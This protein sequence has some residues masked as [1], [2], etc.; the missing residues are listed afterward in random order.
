MISVVEDP[1]LRFAPRQREWEHLETVAS[2]PG[3]SS[4]EQS[5]SDQAQA[6]EKILCHN[7]R[8]A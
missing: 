7:Y 6:E 8:G 1:F 5:A 2:K 4:R 3:C